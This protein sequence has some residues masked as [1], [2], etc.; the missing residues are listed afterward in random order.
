MIATLIP[1]CPLAMKAEVVRFIEQTGFRVQVAETGADTLVGVVGSPPLSLAEQLLALEG[2]ADVQTAAPPYPMVSR[3]HHPQ[4]SVVKIEGVNFGGPTVQVIAGPCSVESED[5]I[6][7]S[8]RAA[9]AAGAAL[10]RGGAFKPRTS[11]YSFQG[12]GRRGLELLAQARAETGLPVVTEVVAP[13]DVEMV[14]ELADVL[15]IGARNMQ[16]FRLLEAAGRQPKPVLLKRGMSATI[17]ELLLAAEYVVSNGNPRLILCERGI[18]TYEKATR[19]TLDIGA[20]PLLKART[21][22]PVIVDPS[23]ACGLR[24]LV[25]A[26]SLAAIA[27]GADGLIVEMHPEPE[28]ALSDGRQ[29]LSPEGLA[30]MMRALGPVAEAVGRRSPLGG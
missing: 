13:E 20:V 10:L 16:N 17:D 18:R 2:V 11:P 28:R 4:D 6:L 12:L 30:D 25:P 3:A 29:S 19:N 21:H 23:H 5:Q 1:N 15:Q 7:A 22:L 14:S 9:K 26:L 8:A 24:E 27:A